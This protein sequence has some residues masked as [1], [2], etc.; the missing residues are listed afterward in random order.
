M[1]NHREPRPVVY[2]RPTLPMTDAEQIVAAI[3]RP[4]ASQGSIVEDVERYNPTAILLVDGIFQ[5]E[6]AVRHKEILWALSR[7]MPVGRRQHGRVARGRAV[8]AWHD[9]RWNDL[10]LVQAVPF[11]T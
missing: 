11:P 7:G 3:Y 10:P 8:A 4:P 9:W 2:L 5:G 1:A 6:P